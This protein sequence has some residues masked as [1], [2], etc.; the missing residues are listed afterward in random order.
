MIVPADIAPERIQARLHSRVIGR[1]L[2]V[3]AE[4]GSTNDFVMAEGHRGSPEG[5][6]VLADRQTAGRGR[7]G[8]AWA[9]PPGVGLY[10]S[11]LL[12]P[13]LPPIQTPLITL[14]AGLAVAG[15]IREVTELDPRVKWPNDVLVDGRKVAG[16]L[17]ELATVG[18]SVGHVVVGIGINVNQDWQD[19]PEGVRQGATSLRLAAGRVIGRADLAAAVYAS[20]DQWYQVF[21]EGRTEAI[22]DRGRE[23]S[24]TLGKPVEVSEGEGTWRALAVD[25]DAY[26]A[27]LVRDEAGDL[28]RLVAGEVRV[29]TSGE[30]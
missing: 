19:L 10:T 20:F 3:L 28:R 6:A 13:H 23:W 7:L 8:R 30:G 2:E 4:V 14:A 27:L 25:L 29:R 16:I 15:A 26:G 21:S 18:S 22:L 17:T 12:R 5:F 9:S 24:A 1:P 11:I